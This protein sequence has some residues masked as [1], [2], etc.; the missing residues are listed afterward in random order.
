MKET[1]NKNISYAEMD[2]SSLKSVRDFANSLS[3]L[4]PLYAVVCNAGVQF[5]DHTH[6]SKEGFEETFAVN[7][8][9]HF[10]SSELIT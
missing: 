4:P 3:N 7:H 1:K 5:V 9:S 8:L 10:S 2:L 6:Y